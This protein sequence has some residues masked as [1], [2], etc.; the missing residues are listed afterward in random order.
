MKFLL[1]ILV[2][3]IAQAQAC[4]VFWATFKWP[5]NSMEAHLIDN[6]VEVC[7][8]NG[9]VDSEPLPLNCIDGQTAYIFKKDNAVVWNREGEEVRFSYNVDTHLMSQDLWANNYGC[10]C[11]EFKCK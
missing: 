8:V 7:T 1:L 4:L 2:A 10:R 3:F 6:G 5:S 11:G 9:K